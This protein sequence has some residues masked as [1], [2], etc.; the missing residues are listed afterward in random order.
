[1]NSIYEYLASVPDVSHPNF[2]ISVL[3]CVIIGAILGLVIKGEN[4]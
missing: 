2:W 3:S 4:K 1:M